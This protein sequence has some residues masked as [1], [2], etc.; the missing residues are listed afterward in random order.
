MQ[1][2][3][4]DDMKSEGSLGS[5]WLLE[6]MERDLSS[7]CWNSALLD[8]PFFKMADSGA[9]FIIINSKYSSAFILYRITLHLGLFERVLKMQQF[10]NK[11][12]STFSSPLL[13]WFFI[14]INYDFPI[15][16]LLK[17]SF[18]SCSAFKDFSN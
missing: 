13:L 1:M 4:Q 14:F 9:S 6:V 2:D 15:V 5:Q 16:Y 7:N 17:L 8:I 11:F 12:F 18:I 3:V 10:I